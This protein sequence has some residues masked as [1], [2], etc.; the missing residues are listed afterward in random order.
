MIYVR[1]SLPAAPANNGPK[2]PK[3]QCIQ[4]ALQ[5]KFGNFLA[6]KVIS[7]FSLLSLADNWRA[8]ASSSATLFSLTA[9]IRGVNMVPQQLAH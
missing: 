5:N 3:Q 7:E 9:S 1:C 2:Q 4:N 6:N 8:F